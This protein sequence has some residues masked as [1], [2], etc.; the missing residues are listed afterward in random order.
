[1]S[2]PEFRQGWPDVVAMGDDGAGRPEWAGGRGRPQRPTR[3]QEQT[4]VADSVIVEAL[5][6]PIGRGRSVTGA[7]SGFHASQ[8]L[9]HLQRGIVDRAGIDPAD[10]DQVIGGCVTQAGEQASNVTR[11][12]WLTTG[13][14]YTTGATTVD[15][16]CGSGQQANNLISALV[17]NGTIDVGLACGV[18]LMS[19]VGLG[20]NTRNGPGRSKPDDFPWDSPNQ[21]EAA[22]R[23]A[24]NRGI[25]REQVDGW[26]LRSQL[27][28][29]AAQS[30]GR[31]DR[32]ILPVDVPILDDGGT[33]TGGTRSVTRDQGPRDSTAEGLARLEPVLEGGIHTAGNSSQISDG[34]AGLLHM[35]PE[36]AR[37][38]G[39]APRA[40]IVANVVV[41]V[42]PYYLLD[43]PIDATARIL[44]RSGMSLSD[45]DL[46]EC[47]EAFAVVVLS[48]LQQNPEIDP[49]K[50]NVNGGA[51][52][53]GHPVGATGSRL[54]V[55][56]LHELERRDE[57]TA[58][59]TM[60][61]GGAI[62]TATII[63]RI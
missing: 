25:T 4:T 19:H 34:A 59:V 29:A 13:D 62:G 33:P 27:R 30:E 8:L 3:H 35:T 61:C 45:I 31:F 14:D 5:R 49:D 55:T 37:R 39:L 46:F 53:L 50:V 6:T 18:E 12:A 23:I 54:I 63:E 11:T 47:N 16:Q 51:I 15:S 1:M 24:A 10:V 22:E 7:L 36:R 57:T 48:W 44:E 56:A 17:G 21:F 41:G 20:M 60:C 28:A 42:D 58:L 32:E 26:G 43:G 38:F 40:R 2:G 52:A 9:G